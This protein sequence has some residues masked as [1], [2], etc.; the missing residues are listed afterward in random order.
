MASLVIFALVFFAVNQGITRQ[1]EEEE[2]SKGLVDL[3]TKEYGDERGTTKQLEE[4]EE[5]NGKKL[6]DLFTKKYGDERILEKSICLIDG[7]C[8]DIVD[9]IESDGKRPAIVRE[10][11]YD[12][13]RLTSLLLKTPFDLTEEKMDTADWRIDRRTPRFDTY[14]T[15]MIE[16]MFT[17]GAISMN[18]KV[19]A[20]VLSLGLGGGN[21]NSYLH[22][23]YR[24]LNITVVEYDPQM[25]NISEFWCGLMLDEM[26]RVIIADGTEFV[27]KCADQGEKFDVIFL[28]ACI[29]DH[30]SM[31]ICPAQ[32]FVAANVANDLANILKS[33]GW[34]FV[35]IC[36][37]KN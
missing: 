24:N 32:K 36:V 22:H 29:V 8:V 35:L 28:D 23:N 2:E 4:E 33:N 25:L 34:F 12:S 16:E 11:G 5:D 3:S 15:T 19:S 7:T 18:R 6:V 17:S 1:L 10:I 27:K 30:S 21:L 14:V 31:F 26:H 9:R 20:S 37:S 13:I